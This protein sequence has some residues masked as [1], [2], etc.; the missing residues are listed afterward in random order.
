MHHQRV[1]RDKK[2][3]NENIERLNS[4]QQE[5]QKKYE[6]LGQKYNFTMKEK[7]L[8]K[9]ERDKL[10]AETSQKKDPLPSVQKPPPD[11]KKIKF[12]PFP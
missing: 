2:K 6:Q 4:L 11:N 7:M 8:I 9:I 3:L 5:Y 10:K 12:T 1:Q